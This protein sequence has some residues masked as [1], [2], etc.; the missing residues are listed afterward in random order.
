MGKPTVAIIGGGL[1]GCEAA[2]QLGKR[3]YHVQLFEMRPTTMTPAHHTGHLSELVC[4]NSLKSNRLDNA[5]G[6]LKQEL[7]L[8]GSL[9]MEAADATCVPAGQA[10]AV[11]RVLFSKY[12]E[13]KL[14]QYPNVE[15]I[16]QEVLELPKT[17]AVIIATGPVTSDPFS[18]F[19]SSLLGEEHLY[20]Y[21]AAAPIVLKDQLDFSKVYYKSRYDKAGGDDYINCPFTKNEYDSFYHELVSAKTVPLKTFEKE[22]YFEGCLP[23]EVIAKRGEKTLRFGPLKPV[24]L[25]K[26]DGTRP[27][28]V[29]QLRQDD[30]AASMYNL[31][32]FQTNLTYK[33]Q[34]RVF[35]MIPGLE[36]AEF[37]RYGVMHRNTFINSPQKLLPSLALKT[38]S[39]VFVAGQLSGV[40]GY[41]ESAAMGLVSALNVVRLFHKD[42][43]AIAPETTMIGS[44][45]RYITNPSISRFQP[46][47]AN[48]GILKTT[49]KDKQKIAENACED[50]VRWYHGL[51]L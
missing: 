48:Y 49:L 8:L 14:A 36:N 45:Q 25:E 10:L 32:G 15:I 16:H 44:L 21:D 24:G 11:D 50:I 38:A 18:H 5:A 30:S 23:I 19:L 35:R 46:M 29:V 43:E 42:S 34:E 26:S 39:F 37:V 51:A 6:L 27:Y 12:I 20:F 22:I 41:V 7:R 1:A 4:S 28:A 13:Q 40:E 3:G 9:F 17:D 2:Y 31:V 33:E 47:N